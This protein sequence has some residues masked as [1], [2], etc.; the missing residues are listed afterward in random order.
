MTDYGDRKIKKNTENWKTKV[1]TNTRKQILYTSKNQLSDKALVELN[2]LDAKI[3]RDF[4]IGVIVN[5]NF[6][7]WAY[8]NFNI[9][10]L[11]SNVARIIT[12]RCYQYF[13]D[14]KK[15]PYKNIEAI[16]FEMLKDRQIPKDLAEEI[17]EDILPDL[18]DQYVNE[19]IDIQYLRHRVERYLKERLIERRIQEAETLKDNNDLY[20]AAEIIHLE[21]PI[22]EDI[23]NH[24]HTAEEIKDLGIEKPKMLMKPWLRQGET[25]FLYSE[26]GVGKSLLAILIAYL[27]GLNEYSDEKVEIKEWQ[28]KNP[29]GTLYIDG[30]L[31]LIEMYERLKHYQWIGNQ[32]QCKK[33]KVFSR[34]N[35]RVITGKDFSLS[36]RNNQKNILDWFKKNPNYKVLIID[37]VSTCFDL[38]NENDNSEWNKKINP[39]LADLRALGVAHIVLHHAGK[40][41]KRGLRG[42]SAMNALAHNIIRLTDHPDKVPGQAWF[43]VDNADKQRAEGKLFDPF[44]IRF[45]HHE[46]RTDWEITETETQSNYI[47][48]L[49]EVIKGEKSNLDIAKEFGLKSGENIN[50]YKKKGLK[51]GY[52]EKEGSKYKPTKKGLDLVKEVEETE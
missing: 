46:G 34:N 26:A 45:I 18:S 32:N 35:Y 39:F 8:E 38:E 3:E 24:F 49:V 6:C 52:L 40:D 19:G 16:Y 11:Q 5:D 22:A 14:Y 10:Y 12:S 1:V 31:G 51:D 7:E 9:N 36:E 21:L 33:T 50:W 43:K 47:S 27:L 30:E 41:S 42:A 17:E 29:T 48:I 20:E 25:N 4:V 15:A 2:K 44:Y 28:V 37:S 13:S 23:S